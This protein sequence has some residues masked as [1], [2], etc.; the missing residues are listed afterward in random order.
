MDCGARVRPFALEPFTVRRA[1]EAVEA[2]EAEELGVAQQD[3]AGLAQASNPGAPTDTAPAH[4]VRPQ[5][6]N[7]S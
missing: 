4:P 6:T 5:G 2:E 7:H 1:E 3:C